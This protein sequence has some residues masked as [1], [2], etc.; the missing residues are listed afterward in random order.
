MQFQKCDRISIISEYYTK[1]KIKNNIF[2]GG[3]LNNG[4]T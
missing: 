1:L 2:T 4:K 3:L